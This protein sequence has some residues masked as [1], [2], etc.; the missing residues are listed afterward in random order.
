M[1]RAVEAV[2]EK[3]YERWHE[4]AAR[5]AAKRHSVAKEPSIARLK[6]IDT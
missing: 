1:S 4:T 6:L 5:R 2:T 3:D